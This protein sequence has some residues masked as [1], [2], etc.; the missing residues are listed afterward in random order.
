[1]LVGLIGMIH[2]TELKEQIEDQLDKRANQQ[3]AEQLQ[4]AFSVLLYEQLYWQ[5]RSE[6]EIC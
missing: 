4:K 6:L 3:V 5:L 1:M 2:R